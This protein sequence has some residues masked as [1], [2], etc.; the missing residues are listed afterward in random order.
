MFNQVWREAVKASFYRRVGGK[1]VA[2][3]R[4]G[5]RRFEGLTAPL[6]ETTRALQHGER[7]M[8]VIQVTDF[9]LDA[10]CGEQ[11]PTAD[12]ERQFLQ[13]TLVWPA[14]VKLAGDGTAWRLGVRAA[15]G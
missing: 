3:P 15:K 7:R 14:P 6:F 12:P 10:E 13:Q 1:E 8:P 2:C 9:G 11:P 5:Q 4:D